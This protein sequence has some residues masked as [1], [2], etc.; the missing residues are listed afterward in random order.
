LHSG[1][2][3]VES[4]LSLFL[5]Y[6]ADAQ[7]DPNPE[8]SFVN[9]SSFVREDSD[10]GC[11]CRGH[12]L[13]LWGGGAFSKAAVEPGKLLTSGFLNPSVS[14]LFPFHGSFVFEA[15]QLR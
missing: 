10:A 1:D 7:A 6:R 13:L 2:F 9:E 4:F 12:E 5:R 8:V 14:L 3:G 15:R 11:A